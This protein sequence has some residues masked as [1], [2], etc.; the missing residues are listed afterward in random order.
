M[1]QSGALEQ[2]ADV[3]NFNLDGAY[4]LAGNREPV[5]IHPQSVLF[6][7]DSQPEFIVFHELQRSKKGKTYMI[8]CTTI[9]SQWL[10][11]VT[12]GTHLDSSSAASAA[13]SAVVPSSASSQQPYQR[14]VPPLLY[15]GLPREQPLPCY[16]IRRD[17]VQCF[18]DATFGIHRWELPIQKLQYPQL[19]SAQQSDY[20]RHFARL[21]LDGYVCRDLQVLRPYLTI[22]PASLL[23]S[24]GTKQSTLLLSAFNRQK[25]SSLTQLRALWARDP[26]ALLD[27][28]KLWVQ[29]ARHK[30]LIKMWPPA[31]AGGAE[32][33]E[34]MEVD[35]DEEGGGS[36]SSKKSNKKKKKKQKIV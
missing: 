2:F 13:A 31:T 11:D 24:V 12:V 30:E 32:D 26:S 9:D 7:R 22:R 36:G 27:V 5:F 19:T 3:E 34:R 20:L 25:L 8:D 28:M 29:P 1:Q 17:I 14:L 4:Q 21:F 16:N 10:A 6:D 18:V 35:G 33:G 23:S 15:I